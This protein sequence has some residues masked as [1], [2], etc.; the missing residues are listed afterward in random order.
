[1]D[2]SALVNNFQ[3]KG[4][5]PMAANL[6]IVNCSLKALTALPNLEDVKTQLAGCGFNRVQVTRFM[7]RSEFYGITAYA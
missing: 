3:S 4:R 1:M 7:P 5:G 2:V 6:N